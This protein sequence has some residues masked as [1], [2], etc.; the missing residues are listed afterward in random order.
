MVLLLTHDF[1]FVNVFMYSYVHFQLI[2]IN[3][4]KSKGP[5]RSKQFE[6]ARKVVADTGSEYSRLVIIDFRCWS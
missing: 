1:L 4:K 5:M 6:F 3:M 2:S